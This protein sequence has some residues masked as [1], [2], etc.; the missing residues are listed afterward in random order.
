MN[1]R[2]PIMVKLNMKKI[3]ALT[4]LLAM[5]VFGAHAAG[6]N[7]AALLAKVKS[8]IASSP[9]VEA[10]FSIN[11]GEG[12]VQGSAT[13]AGEKYFMTTP[14]LT[15]W[16]DGRT[17]WTFLK[18]SNEVSITEPEVADL[19]AS[20]PFAILSAP[21][22]SYKLR[23]LSDSEGRKRVELTPKSPLAGIENIVLFIKPATS[24]PAAIVVRFDDGR[25]VDVV[26]DN[27][28]AGASKPISAFRYD[29]KRFPAQEVIDL[30]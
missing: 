29:A 27:I 6:N 13:M 26:I 1:R 28:A 12:P 3:F 30:R 5:V 20:T 7:A 21:A 22:D 15:V 23:M 11:G 25:R 2:H 24:L 4:A 17:Q 19:M 10:T 16:Y 9:S 14:V 8:K 18:S